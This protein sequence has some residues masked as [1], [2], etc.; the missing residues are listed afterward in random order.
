[1]RFGVL[2]TGR[3][4]RRLVADLQ[5]TDRVDVTAIA[6]RTSDRAQWYA[7]QYGIAHAVTG[8][9]VL[10]DRDDVDAV[11]LS[12]P[13]S[14]HAEWS[15]RAAECGKHVLCEKPLALSITEVES[16]DE[17]CK[18]SGV[19]WLDATGWLHHPR[20]EA[21][22]EL[23]ADKRLGELG[24]ITAA[25]S[26]YQ[27]FQ[28]GDHRLD[29]SLGGGCLLDLGWYAC[30][31]ARFAAGVLPTAVSAKVLI[32]QGVPQRLTAILDFPGEVTATISCGYDTATRK[33]FEVAGS[34]A[35]LICNDFTRPWAER[36]TRF[37]LH[38]AAGN[39]QTHTIEGSQERHMIQRF[40]SDDSLDFWQRQAMDTQRIL[41]VAAQ[42]ADEGG[43]RVS[44]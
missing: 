14:M 8:Y 37:S 26:F 15:I 31:A 9:S 33:W 42:S 4:T 28:S 11:Y 39:T 27:P 21:F 22:Q 19:R 41:D 13:P 5:S 6:S 12:L 30:G 34:A 3:I 43:V 2:G 1:M 35:S 23:L 16:I 38:D 17:A 32:R 36:P 29:P 18:S 20:T 40:I 7:D 25:V 44:V 10:L 24:H